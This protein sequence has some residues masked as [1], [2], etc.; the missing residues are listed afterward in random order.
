MEEKLLKL[1]KAHRLGVDDMRD[2][3]VMQIKLM[4]GLTEE[5]KK[6]ITTTLDNLVVLPTRIIKE[7][8]NG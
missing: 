3:V 1:M 2:A 5:Q 4:H 7:F 8:P 6:Q